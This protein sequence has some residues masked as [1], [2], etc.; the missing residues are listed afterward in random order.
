MR[1]SLN[2]IANMRIIEYIKLFNYLRDVEE[3][4]G[5]DIIRTIY[6]LRKVSKELLTGVYL[7]LQGKEPEISINGVTYEEL[8]ERDGMRPIRAILMLDWVRREPE[9]AFA[10]MAEDFRRAPIQPL[11]DDEKYELERAIEKLKGYVEEVPK[12]VNDFEDTNED[13][14]INPTHEEG[15]VE[16][17]NSTKEEPVDNP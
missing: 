16:A 14:V 10:Y 5:M 1:I 12:S 9:A 8:V 11:N 15:E 3:L 4:E 7:I 13:I 2:I 17:T 6:R